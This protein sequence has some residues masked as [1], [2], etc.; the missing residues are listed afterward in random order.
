M[1]R[2]S[3]NLIGADLESVRWER[4]D[5]TPTQDEKLLESLGVRHVGV[6]PGTTR[7]AIMLTTSGGGALGPDVVVDAAMGELETNRAKLATAV[8]AVERHLFVWIDGSA[9]LA[10]MS[11]RGSEPPSSEAPDFGSGVDVLWVAAVDVTRRPLTASVLWRAEPGGPW[12]D[13]TPRINRS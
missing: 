5:P 3:S 6:V 11:L 13:W 2:L 8:D 9:A 4:L 12:A 7:S 10:S 1:P